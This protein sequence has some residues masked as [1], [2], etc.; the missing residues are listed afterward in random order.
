MGVLGLSRDGVDTGTPLL[1]GG[2]GQGWAVGP[3]TE[4]RRVVRLLLSGPDAQ[5]PPYAP[6]SGRTPL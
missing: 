3:P 4:R 1:D 5:V 2:P 6:F